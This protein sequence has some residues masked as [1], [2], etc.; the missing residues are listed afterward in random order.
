MES[1][2]E[3][4]Q[5]R[6]SPAKLSQGELP[7]RKLPAFLMDKKLKPCNLM[8]ASLK[9]GKT[10]SIPLIRFTLDMVRFDEKNLHQDFLSKMMRKEF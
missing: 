9:G 1:A 4:T 8:L 2:L 7:C 5:L 3:G 6:F 10:S